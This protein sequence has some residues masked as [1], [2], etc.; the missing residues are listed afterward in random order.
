MTWAPTLGLTRVELIDLQ[1]WPA[2]HNGTRLPSA[3]GSTTPVE[4]EEQCRIKKPVVGI[5]NE[6]GTSE[7]P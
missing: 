3:L 1:A 2:W 5:G 4:F 7:E 6:M